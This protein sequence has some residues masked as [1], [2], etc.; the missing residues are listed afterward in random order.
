MKRNLYWIPCAAHCIN[1]MLEDFEKIQLH[2]K[3]IPM[4]K[5]IT[6]HIYSRTR[7]ISV[8]HHFT[9]GFDLIRPV[10]TRFA[11]YY[12]CLRCLNKNKGALDGFS[13]P[14]DGRIVNFQRQKKENLLKI[15]SLIRISTRI[16]Q[17]A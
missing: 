13:H 17:I 6:I 16:F 11:T 15:K 14:R 5:R 3:T 8:L 9:R 7:P 4:G 2:Q 12:L 1:L 10:I